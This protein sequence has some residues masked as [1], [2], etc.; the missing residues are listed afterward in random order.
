MAR[1]LLS[2]FF[3]T[4]LFFSAELYANDSIYIQKNIREIEITGKGTGTK[5]IIP[6][7]VLIAPNQSVLNNILE[8]IPSFETDLEG[9]VRLRGSDKMTILI[10]TFALSSFG[11]LP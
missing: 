8:L 1:K 2:A 7:D 11:L 9:N 3:I 4:V 6:S 5:C 10:N